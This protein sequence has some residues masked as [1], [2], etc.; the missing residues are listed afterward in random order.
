MNLSLWQNFY[1]II[2]SSAGA[3]V[4]LQFIAI[5]LISSTRQPADFASVNAF[6]T[7]NVVHFSVALI[8]SA[9]MNAPWSSMIALSVA[10]AV[11]GLLGLAYSANVFHRTRRQTAYKPIAEDWLWYAILPCCLYAALTV[12]APLLWT[13][14]QVGPFMVAGVALGLLLVGIRNAWDSVTHIVVTGHPDA[15]KKPE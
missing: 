7:P 1:V 13:A 4:G 3:L 2:G 5:V 11:C 6:G 15:A 8:V 10:L 12:A 9:V 14:G